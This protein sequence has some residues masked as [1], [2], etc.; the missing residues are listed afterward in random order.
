VL[1]MSKQGSGGFPRINLISVI[2]GA[3]AIAS[4]FLPWWG[5]D[6]SGLG[7]TSSLRWT[8]WNGPA[9]ESV[10]KGSG[11]AYPTLN[12]A[13]PIIGALV[14]ISAV[15]VLAG[16]FKANVKPLVGGFILTVAI[17]IAYLGIVS[18]AVTSACSGQPYC[19]SGPS[20]TETTFGFTLNWGFQLGFY[21]YL[22]AGTLTLV[23]LGFHRIFH[24]TTSTTKTA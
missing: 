15:L 3:L 9:T 4:V 7:S 2:A 8:L 10:F 5:M 6:A 13:S 18:Y 16:S 21:L 17:S 19:L 14:V 22:V 20:G 24:K 11:Q 12:S 1:A 23:A